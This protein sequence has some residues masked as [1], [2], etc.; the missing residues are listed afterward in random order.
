[1]GEFVSQEH[2]E[3]ENMA[4]ASVGEGLDNLP[5][6]LCYKLQSLAWPIVVLFV[7]Q[8]GLTVEQFAM[9]CVNKNMSGVPPLYSYG[10]QFVVLVGLEVVCEKVRHLKT[11]RLFTFLQMAR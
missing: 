7:K 9:V 4:I 6:L 10:Q 2:V 5:L 1:M 11:M 8:F 3:E